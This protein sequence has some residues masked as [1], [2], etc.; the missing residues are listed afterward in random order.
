VHSFI[1][2]AI[3]QTEKLANYI[4]SIYIYIYIYIYMCIILKAITSYLYVCSQEHINYII[5]V[6][7]KLMLA[8]NA[9]NSL[10][11]M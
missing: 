1:R 11:N 10:L 6:V 5:F 2:A 8:P 9:G 7:E 3:V 4:Y